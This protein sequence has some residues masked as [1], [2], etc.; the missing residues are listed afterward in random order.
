LSDLF[1][2][3]GN[4][5]PFLTKVVDL[6]CAHHYQSSSHLGPQGIG[7]FREKLSWY[8]LK[9]NLQLKNN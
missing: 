9:L 1:I 2:A 8:I 6:T 4:T 5:I 7:A 3:S